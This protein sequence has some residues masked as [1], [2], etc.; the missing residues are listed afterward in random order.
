MSDTQEAIAKQ[1]AM[2]I[3]GAAW[4]LANAFD[5]DLWCRRS[6]EAPVQFVRRVD[7]YWCKTH[8]CWRTLGNE[9]YVELTF[10]RVD[11]CDNR[12]PIPTHW[13]PRPWGPS[14]EPC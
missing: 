7:A 5:V 14:G 2:D 11:G 10:R 8:K 1:A 9:H 13:R 4:A 6:W 12:Y 3:E